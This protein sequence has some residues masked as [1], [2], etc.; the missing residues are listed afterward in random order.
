MSRHYGRLNDADVSRCDQGFKVTLCASPAHRWRR[1]ATCLGPE[2]W[3]TGTSYLGSQLAR[4]AQSFQRRTRLGLLG[5]VCSFL[6]RCVIASKFLGDAHEQSLSTGVFD[7]QERA[8]QFDTRP[9]RHESIKR[10]V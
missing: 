5:A 3:E 7:L 6:R 4:S 1:C 10:I 9:V 2:R 8:R